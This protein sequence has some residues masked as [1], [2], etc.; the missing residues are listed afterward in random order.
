MTDMRATER[1]LEVIADGA[2]QG[3]GE[4]REGARL[5]AQC[6]NDGL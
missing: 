2:S 1:L 3:R 6:D 5:P 4:G